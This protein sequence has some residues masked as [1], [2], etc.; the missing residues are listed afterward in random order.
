MVNLEKISDL[1]EKGV[2]NPSFQN[3]EGKF[4]MR[5]WKKEV[6]EYTEPFLRVIT[7][8]LNEALKQ[9]RD[10]WKETKFKILRKY[11]GKQNKISSLQEA[12][13]KFP[14][15]F[16][17]DARGNDRRPIEGFIVIC[18]DTSFVGENYSSSICWGLRWWGTAQKAETVHEVFRSLNVDG[19]LTDSKFS[20]HFG[21]F[22]WLFS[23]MTTE[24]LVTTGVESLS[25]IIT[26]DFLK[27]FSTL[28]RKR[29]LFGSPI[30][31]RTEQDR[32]ANKQPT[33]G[34]VEKAIL[35]IWSKSGQTKINKSDV[36][37]AM[38]SELK[39]KGVRLKSD[40]RKSIEEKLKD[41]FG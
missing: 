41:W 31:D 12:K 29:E 36:L 7:E 26:Q 38:E 11:N 15:P 27:L 22:A 17:I 8:K 28:F 20:D 10:F 2:E 4:S 32:G 24:Q 3:D 25:E 21:T 13:C 23:S 1:L 35:R 16:V 14:E 33:R 40:W 30:D 6:Q 9:E 34:D 19:K 5:K 37:E 18:P 39:K